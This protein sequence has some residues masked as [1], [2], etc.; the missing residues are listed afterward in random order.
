VKTSYANLCVM[1][2]SFRGDTM[3]PMILWIALDM[4][5]G[6]MNITFDEPIRVRLTALQYITLQ[7]TPV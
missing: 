6:V 7:S 2:C 5:A 4:D 1:V 3:H